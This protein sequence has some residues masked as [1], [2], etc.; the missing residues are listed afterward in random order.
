[1]GENFLAD[2]KLVYGVIRR[3]Y[4]WVRGAEIED[5]RQEGR[6][7]LIKAREKFCAGKGVAFSTFAEKCIENEINQYLRRV[8]AKEENSVESI[9][10]VIGRL[11][12][13]DVTWEDVLEDESLRVEEILERKEIRLMLYKEA[14]GMKGNKSEIMRLWLEGYDG[15]Q[16]GEIFGVS[17]QRVNQVV[18]EYRRA[19]KQKLAKAEIMDLEK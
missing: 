19:I 9:S 13:D 4:R 6:K 3:K 10:G 17:R 12:N 8:R 7:G 14:E 2:E 5:I 1:M 11:E 18:Q 15:A 16:I